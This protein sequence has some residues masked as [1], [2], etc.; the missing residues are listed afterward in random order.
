VHILVGTDGSDGAGRAVEFA[1]RLS[2][3]LKASL[4]IV[5]V[6][7]V[8]DPPLDAHTDHASLARKRA[9]VLGAVDVRSESLAGTDV[10]ETLI[11]AAGRDKADLIVVGKRGLS[12]LSGLLLGSVSQRLISAAPCAVI[13]V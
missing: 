6:V 5:H 10:A 11:E 12:R 1:A 3:D 2:R 7:T 4:K 13:V 9:E 8:N